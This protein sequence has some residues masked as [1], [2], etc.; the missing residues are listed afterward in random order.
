MSNQFFPPSSGSPYQHIQ[1]SPR[2]ANF[3]RSNTSPDLVDVD[4]EGNHPSSSINTNTH[5]GN[6]NGRQWNNH[7]PPASPAGFHPHSAPA[8]PRKPNFVP[9]QFNANAERPS[10]AINMGGPK[11]LTRR[12]GQG[13]GSSSSLPPSGE[14]EEDAGGSS[15]KKMRYN[16]HHAKDEKKAKDEVEDTF[17]PMEAIHVF[18]S[19]AEL[20]DEWDK[21]Q[22]ELVKFLDNYAKDTL[23]HAYENIIQ[24]NY[25]FTKLNKD[26][27]ENLLAGVEAIETEESGHEKARKII[28]DFSAEMKR[29]AE[30]LSRFGNQDNA[31]K[32][33]LAKPEGEVV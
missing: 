3:G 28:T 15:R 22:G 7:I 8:T 13:T 19:K 11:K 9:P 31:L 33:I 4:E 17:D 1:P 10:P 5:S 30:V 29:A 2:A 16:S 32:A 12:A 23:A 27:Q 14:E 18:D 21:I 6:G 26:A 25:I 20:E 24:V